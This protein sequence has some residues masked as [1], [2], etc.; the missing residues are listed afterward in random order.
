MADDDDND[1]YY[2]AHSEDDQEILDRDDYYDTEIQ[3]NGHDPDEENVEEE[4]AD[5]DETG[6]PPD[7]EDI[8][9]GLDSDIEQDPDDP[10]MEKI[11]EQMT[12]KQE[13][14]TTPYMTKFEYSYLISQRALAIENG[15]PLMY[16]ETSFI[17]SIDIAREET[18]MGLNP[19]IIQRQIPPNI[20]EEWKCSEL[21]L[22][23]YYE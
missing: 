20:I 23:E 8:D 7:Q 19:I 2:Y 1:S 22:P 21:K 12:S 16:P 17:H 13:R 9:D 3:L 15:S 18:R 4:R 10:P 6:V 11:P 14:K 5:P